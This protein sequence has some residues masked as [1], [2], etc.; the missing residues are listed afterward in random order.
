MS[1][2]RTRLLLNDIMFFMQYLDTLHEQ[3]SLSD[4]F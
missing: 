4:S 2:K 3:H 1:I